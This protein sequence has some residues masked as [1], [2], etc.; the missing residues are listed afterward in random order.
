MLVNVEMK[1]K[2]KGSYLI[3]DIGMLV[4]NSEFY[5]G[6]EDEHEIELFINEDAELNIH[7]WEGYFSDI[8]G[9]PSFDREGWYGFTRDFQQC[10]RTFEEKDVDINVDEYLLDLLNYKNKT[11]R[12]EETKD[13]YELMRTFL[14]YA[15]ANSKTV[16]VNWW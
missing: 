16:K 14:E 9:E 15:K 11:F 2:S 3:M 7:I 8:F 10:E 13:C 4:N 5:D 6:F 1:L 12:F